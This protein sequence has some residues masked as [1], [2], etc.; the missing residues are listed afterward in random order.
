MS[1][2][3][4]PAGRR[5]GRLK[6]HAD[7]RDWGMRTAPVFR[8]PITQLPPSVDLSSFNGP[9]KD[10]GQ[11]G[12][13]TGHAYSSFREF[14]ARKFQS[15][16]PIL[17]PQFLYVSEL[18]KERTFPNDNGAMPRTGCLVL[19][20]LGCCEESDFPYVVE[21]LTQPTQSQLDAAKKWIGGAYHRIGNLADLLSCLASGYC[22]SVGFS[23]YESF[24][25]EQV[26]NT[27]I[28]PM[29]QPNEQLLGGHEVLAVGY[30]SASGY[31]KI[32]NSWG[33]SWGLGGYFKMPF[34]YISNPAYVS[35]LWLTHLGRA[36]K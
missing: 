1:L 4:S 5:Y 24:E 20:Q 25:S 15:E 36:W 27:G 34:E 2:P 18:L 35:D 19:N 16:S 32:Q 23:V 11:E 8:L 28:M 12:S 21:G 14:L 10:Q 22:A 29:P 7:V 17:S 13:C 31:V 30:D 9:I 33:S 6:D 26:A 3:L